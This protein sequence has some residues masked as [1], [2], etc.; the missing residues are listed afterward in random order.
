MLVNDGDVEGK[1]R[2]LGLLRGERDFVRRKATARGRDWI[3]K[4]GPDSRSFDQ[5]LFNCISPLGKKCWDKA[6]WLEKAGRGRR[7]QIRRSKGNS[8]LPSKLPSTGTIVTVQ[9][10]T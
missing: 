3:R 6:G 1:E 9:N 5:A 8:V 4:V 10:T 7:K 2:R